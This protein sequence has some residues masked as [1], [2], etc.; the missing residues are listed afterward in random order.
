LVFSHYVTKKEKDMALLVVN[1]LKKSVKF[2]SYNKR[3][4]KIL[5]VDDNDEYYLGKLCF[6]GV[7]HSPT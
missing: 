6:F 3:M 2:W 5:Y 4:G 7:G 1:N